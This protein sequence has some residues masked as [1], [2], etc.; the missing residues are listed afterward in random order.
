M[1]TMCGCAIRS[2]T[3]NDKATSQRYRASKGGIYKNSE[4]KEKEKEKE[5]RQEKQERRQE[6]EEGEGGRNS[7]ANKRN[8]YTY[9]DR[10]CIRRTEE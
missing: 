3:A 4:R 10:S 8:N 2:D 9:S 1:A 5:K 7:I 6:V